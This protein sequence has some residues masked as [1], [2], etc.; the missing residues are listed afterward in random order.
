MEGWF[1]GL[2]DLLS[3]LT[4]YS[5]EPDYSTWLSSVDRKIQGVHLLLSELIDAAQVVTERKRQLIAACDA[6]REVNVDLSV[7]SF[8]G[9][10]R[11]SVEMQRVR[12]LFL[13]LWSRLLL[14]LDDIHESQ[15]ISLFVET[16]SLLVARSEFDL[17]LLSIDLSL[18][19]HASPLQIQTFQRYRKLM[20]STHLFVIS[21]LAAERP[22]NVR[23]GFLSLLELPASLAK[24]LAVCIHRLPQVG[25][26]IVE[27]IS[28]PA[29]TVSYNLCDY[30]LFLEAA[31][32]S[33]PSTANSANSREDN[34]DSFT[35]TPI[36]AD[37]RPHCIVRNGVDDIAA[38]IKQAD[39]YPRLFEW[40]RFHSALLLLQTED[41]SE[42][43][44]FNKPAAAPSPSPPNLTTPS[45]P[46]TTPPSISS[47][48]NSLSDLSPQGD[49]DCASV[50]PIPPPRAT[51]PKPVVPPRNLKHRPAG[52]N[53]WS[54]QLTSAPLSQS[55]SW[56]KWFHVDSVLFVLL[57]KEWLLHVDRTL[58]NPSFIVLPGQDQIRVVLKNPWIEWT[59][60]EGFSDMQ[61]A[62]LNVLRR[63]RRVSKPIM[64]CSLAL[65]RANP[66]MINYYIH[67]NYS[68]TSVFNIASVAESFA[69]LNMWFRELK[70]TR[71]SLPSSFHSSYFCVGLDLL[72]HTEH[73]QIVGRLVQL[74]YTNAEVFNGPARSHVFSDFLLK[75]NF[76]RLFLHW[77]EA[78][79]NYFHQFLVFK[80]CRLPWRFLQS[81][82]AN[83]PRNLFLPDCDIDS[84][85]A[86]DRAIF[87]KLTAYVQLVEDSVSNP[88]LNLFDDSLRVYIPK[89]LAE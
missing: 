74:L 89:A 40:S 61:E 75:K 53:G 60:V 44:K 58:H 71:L 78:S 49:G 62:F 66:A 45:P 37:L 46:A 38:T 64:D 26:Q 59:A 50:Q 35:P 29:G 76:F 77:D 39:E 85:V 73:H 83:F 10:V 24:F 55:A 43:I 11:S 21:K 18:R 56:T 13:R 63:C 72:L 1:G 19:P 28:L 15:V 65:L 87:S 16:M 7:E 34:S 4:L 52:M 68:R 51:K 30:Q 27:A 47:P 69:Q 2:T 86:L 12:I 42:R 22:V 79:R 3:N 54:E 80:I 82:P 14:L 33:S 36:E 32:P 8:S 17:T 70:T 6:L 5:D 20:I 41:G 23:T 25:S 48:L 84:E 57:F 31:V 67:H 9:N 88:S 81:E